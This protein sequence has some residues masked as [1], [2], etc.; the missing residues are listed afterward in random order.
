MRISF[1]WVAVCL[2]TAMSAGAVLAAEARP[3]R[4]DHLALEQGLS[5]ST[6]S[7]IFQDSRGFLW[8]GTEDGL[9]RFDGYDF[10]VYKHDPSNP[11]SLSHDAVWSIDEDRNGNLWIGT[12]GGGVAVWDRAQDRFVRRSTEEGLSSPYVRVVY[13]ASDGTIWVGTRDAGV[14]SLEPRSGEIRH[15]RAADGSGLSDDRVFAIYADHSG[16]L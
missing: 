5:Q 12:A 3:I 9:N 8:L 13:V 11:S 7:S 10:Q 4:F 1:K 6:V 16:D 2:G 14:D 15:F